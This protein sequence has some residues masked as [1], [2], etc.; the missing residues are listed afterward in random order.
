MQ[1]L[2]SMCLGMAKWSV[3]NPYFVSYSINLFTKYCYQIPNLLVKIT[4]I[5]PQV[6]FPR[7]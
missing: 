2:G 7:R 4:S 5:S 6:Y 1:D 3:R